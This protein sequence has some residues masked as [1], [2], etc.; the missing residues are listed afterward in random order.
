MTVKQQIER[1]EMVALL[2]KAAARQDP[3]VLTPIG[4]SASFFCPIHSV[5]DDEVIVISPIPPELAHNVMQSPG[6]L[7]FCKPYKIE[8]KYLVPR[9]K[10]LA[11]AIP[12]EADLSQDRT[13]ER[14]YLKRTD[15]NYVL[16]Q[17]PYDK[18]TQVRRQ[19]IDLSQ[20]GFSFRA[21]QITPFTQP[22]RLLNEVKIF[23][24]GSLSSTRKGKIVY[25][26]R[27]IESSGSTF[28]QVGVKFK[29]VMNEA[30]T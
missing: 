23:V 19:L 15:D 28:F 30:K 12:K 1:H 3:V 11:F 24:D 16:I 9:G 27:I 22:G 13:D 10:S 14:V 21:Q 25:V 8:A 20:G 2:K 17:H 26:T 29:E 4:L 18:G 7:L 5:S 6:F